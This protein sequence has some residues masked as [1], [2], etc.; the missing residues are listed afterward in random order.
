AR[1]LGPRAGTGSG[2][3]RPARDPRGSLRHPLDHHHQ[4]APTRPVARLPRR[5]H[6]GRLHLRSAAPQC[7]PNRATRTL[8]TK[9]GQA[10]P[11]TASPRVAPLRSPC[12]DLSVHHRAI[13]VFTMTEMRS[14][15]LDGNSARTHRP[16]TAAGINRPLAILRHLL[17]IAHEEWEVLPVVPKVR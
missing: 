8:T 4:P 3:P 5:R 14:L 9:G 10:R 1:R 11:L 16:L 6:R 2:A 13:W 15:R 17:R 12:T 7:P